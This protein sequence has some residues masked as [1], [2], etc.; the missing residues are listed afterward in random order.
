MN[1]V[2][3]IVGMLFLGQQLPPGILRSCT[4]RRMGRRPGVP[5]RGRLSS[6]L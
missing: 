2:R 3:N 4:E 1:K 5:Y 6:D